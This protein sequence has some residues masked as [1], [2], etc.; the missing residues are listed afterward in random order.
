[1]TPTFAVSRL[2]SRLAGAFLAFALVAA[3]VAQTPTPVQPQAKDDKSKDD[4]GKAAT[5]DEQKA[6][7]AFKEGKFDDALKALQAAAKANPAMSPPRLI[8]SRWFLET[9]RG[10]QARVML[11]QAA[12]E[13]PL[14]PEILLTNGN[15]ALNEGRIT[16]TVLN[17]SAALEAANSPRWDAETK[18]RFQREARLGLIAAFDRR[19][20]FAS[21]KT[22]LIALL[23]ADP[24][25]AELRK[26]LATA[27]FLLNRP[28]D[29][30]TDFQTAFKD[31]ST[32]N[33]PELAMA[34]LWNGKLDFTKADEMFQKAAKAYPNAAKVHRA[35]ANYLLDRGRVD[36]AKTHLAAA[37][38]LEPTARDTKA[39]AGL[40]ARY[41]KDYIAAAQIFEE[42]V[43]D[44]PTFDFATACLALVLAESSDP[45]Q[46]R[47]SVELAEVYVQRN[48]RL[49]DAYAVYG[50]C[51]LKNNRLADAEKALATA[52][53]GGRANPDTAYFLARLLAEKGK[54][55][56]AH[57]LLTEAVANPAP[58]VYR[59]DAEALA[60]EL[61]KK[62]PKK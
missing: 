58:F 44:H 10:S 28:D 42:L 18:K 3:A 16:D 41:T 23:E 7:E 53:Q 57:K 54:P 39:I 4:K 55:E 27:N 48:S 32:Q 11:E 31:D 14:H 19:G 52:T 49:A 47:R 37:Q 62:L 20:D 60:A 43:R 61:A 51:L 5:P 17:C 46:K 30:F 50:Y 8:L 45:N 33:P 29:A 6:R 12:A 35:Y 13:D 40:M 26:Q 34:L 2:A 25:N 36:T 22:H 21:A 24:K 56:E 38:Q 9:E 1:M 59:K 15:Y